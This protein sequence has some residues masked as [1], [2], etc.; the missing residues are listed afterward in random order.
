MDGEEGR[1][2]EGGR[3]GEGRGVEKENQRCFLLSLSPLSFL[4]LN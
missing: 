2:G 4:N 1:A 3:E